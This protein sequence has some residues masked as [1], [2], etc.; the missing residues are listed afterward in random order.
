[1]KTCKICLLEKPIS[2]FHLA[3]SN[4]DGLSGFCKSCNWQKEKT[5]RANNPDR[6]KKYNKAH[7]R[8]QRAR[9]IEHLRRICVVCRFD[10]KRAIEI[11]HIYGDGKIGRN[12]IQGNQFM[13]ARRRGEH[14]GQLQVLCANH[15]SI[16]TKEA[17]MEKI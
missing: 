9:I 12:R 16:K 2:S 14:D 1:M 7:I 8:R 3:S 11:D 5:R 4:K 17:L 6:Y 10:D 15:H 13:A